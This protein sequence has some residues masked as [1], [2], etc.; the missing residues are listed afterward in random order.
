MG[1]PKNLAFEI[2]K[3]TCNATTREQEKQSNCPGVVPRIVSFRSSGIPAH[4]LLLPSTMVRHSSRAACSPSIP[5][6]R[7][8]ASNVRRASEV[9]PGGAGG[10]KRTSRERMSPVGNTVF[11]QDWRSGQREEQP[12]EGPPSTRIIS[13][14]E[15]PS[16]DTGRT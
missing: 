9:V 2:Y 4:K 15:P 7:R 12:I 13:L 16:S 14:D 5:E 8:C 11:H 10:I 6:G 3:K 1:P